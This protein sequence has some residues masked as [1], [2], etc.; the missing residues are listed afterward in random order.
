MFR[1]LKKFYKFRAFSLIETMCVL[2]VT[3]MVIMACMSLYSKIKTASAAINRK[4][5]EMTVPLDIIQLVTEDLDRLASE[6]FDT[7]ITIE[8][9]YDYG[10][11]LCQMTIL[12][13]Y[14]DSQNQPQIFEK[15][16]W[17]SSYN[18]E[19]DKLILYRRHSGINLEDKIVDEYRFDIEARDET[20]F[21]PVC[22][23]L[24]YF[25]IRVPV[26]KSLSEQYAMEEY[27]FKE[28]T[29]E[30]EEEDDDEFLDT[31]DQD[32]LPRA[33]SVSVSFA[34]P[35]QNLQGELEVPREEILTRTMAV[36]RTRKVKFKLVTKDLEIP[37]DVLE[38]L[39]ED[40]RPDPNE[41]ETDQPE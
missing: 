13:R 17:Q 5:E 18:F 38:A 15:V 14:L 39:D 36:V 10:Y 22:R 37:E 19:T 2:V 41:I 33:V 16:V 31:W 12:N 11:N 1:P 30:I 25:A 34:E 28:D 8:N 7:K 24:T 21:I 6:G 4:L 29:F 32:K 20:K 9:K 23:G 27:A 40:E 3:S 26:L 35:Y